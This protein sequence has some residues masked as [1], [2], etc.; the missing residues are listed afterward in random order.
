MQK[1][2]TLNMTSVHPN[3]TPRL[4]YFSLCLYLCLSSHA[5]AQIGAGAPRFHQPPL[6]RITGTLVPLEEKQ[7]G[8]L[9]TITVHV[10]GKSWKLRVEKIITLT[11]TRRS[12]SSLLH[13]L[14]PRK[15]H[16]I[17]ADDLLAPLQ[18]ETIVGKPI[19]LEGRLFVGNNQLL[20]S[21]VL[22][23]E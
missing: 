15:L 18:Q 23:N 9:Q 8:K 6:V 17:G 1:P 7:H 22:V 14:F 21:D 16:L 12:G 2:A 19:V 11:A 3:Q 4:V 13:D 5:F 10:K 20:L